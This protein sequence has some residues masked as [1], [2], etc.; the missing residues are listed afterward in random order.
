MAPSGSIIYSLEVVA[1]IL[2]MMVH[3]WMM[4]NPYYQNGGFKDSYNFSLT[5]PQ[6]LREMILCDEHVLI[7]LG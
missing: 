5:P 3:F 4:I 1:T 2:K 7:N 6:L